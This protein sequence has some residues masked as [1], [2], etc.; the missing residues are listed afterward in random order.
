[1]CEAPGQPELVPFGLADERLGV[2]HRRSTLKG[3]LLD[4]R[5]WPTRA[6]ARSAIFEFVEGWYNLHRLHSSLG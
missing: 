5:V 4:H 6:A 2:A 1:M 3:E